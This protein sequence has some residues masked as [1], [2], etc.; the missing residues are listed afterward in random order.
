M[1]DSRRHRSSTRI[2]GGGSTAHPHPSRP[3][4]LRGHAANSDSPADTNT[5][6]VEIALTNARLEHR[7]ESNALRLQIHDVSE[8]LK[9]SKIRAEK[10]QKELTKA[11]TLVAKQVNNFGQIRQSELGGSAVADQIKSEDYY[12]KLI[13][14]LRDRETELSRRCAQRDREIK[15]LKSDSRLARVR[16]LVIEVAEYKREVMELQRS[17]IELNDEVSTAHTNA[18]VLKYHSFAS[19]AN[20]EVLSKM[21]FDLEDADS[22]IRR[23]EALNMQLARDRDKAV[24]E[25]NNL[26][27]A[28][29]YGPSK[30]FSDIT[31]P[32][33]TASRNPPQS[34]MRQERMDSAYATMKQEWENEKRAL[35]D[36]IDTWRSKH[37]AEKRLVSAL[38]T[39]ID[40]LGV[41]LESK[42]GELDRLKSEISMLKLQSYDNHQETPMEREGAAIKIQSVHRG[43]MVR[44]EMNSTRSTLPHTV[45]EDPVKVDSFSNV[46]EPWKS[47][48]ERSFVAHDGSEMDDAAIRI[49]SAYRGRQARQRVAR[50]QAERVAGSRERDVEG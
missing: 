4:F 45:K 19:G 20:T 30:K 33:K 21:K 28:H 42:I 31:S 41:E 32:R 46:G 8:Q 7:N 16:E 38:Q 5:S 1:D 25:K 29:G 26:L 3:R 36:E 17:N 24:R 9:I 12:V 39:E 47:D 49:Q 37:R 27:K 44:R 50:V 14:G 10:L 43:R 13:Q 35:S 2:V 48:D 22:K 34:S 18:G 15:M 6:E 40:E 23:L 11:Q